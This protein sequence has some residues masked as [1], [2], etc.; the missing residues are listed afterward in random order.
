MCVLFISICS[1]TARKVLQRCKEEL[2]P[3]GG[4][5]MESSNHTDLYYLTDL[6]KAL[7][8]DH[9]SK[10]EWKVLYSQSIPG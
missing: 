9:R 3:K 10:T 5:I 1:M 8:T 2:P 6:D 4:H 7:I